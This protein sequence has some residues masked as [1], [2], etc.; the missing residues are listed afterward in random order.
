MP[1]SGTLLDI[2]IFHTWWSF[3]GADDRVHAWIYRSINLVE[4]AFWFGFAVLVLTRHLRNAHRSPLELWYA[5]A[6]FT[7]GLTDVREAWA[8][9]SWLIWLKL[10]NLIALIWIRREVIRRFYPTSK[11]Y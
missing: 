10:L 2:L 4:A 3:A 5:L 11:L 7:F 6:F 9:Q 1:D 8:L